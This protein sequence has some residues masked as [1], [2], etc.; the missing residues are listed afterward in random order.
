MD[1]RHDRFPITLVSAQNFCA[2]A[3]VPPEIFL[4]I[5]YHLAPDDLLSL[6]LVCK[7]YRIYLCCP[8]SSI[9]Q[10]IWRRSRLLYFP[11][12][13][14]PPPAGMDEKRYIQL[15][16]LGDFCQ[17]CQIDHKIRLAVYWP[18]RLR[19][20]DRCLKARIASKTEIRTKLCTKKEK[21]KILAGLPYIRIE[22]VSFYLR[23]QWER[24]EKKYLSLDLDSRTV[25]IE[26]QKKIAQVI[27]KD[28]N[29]RIIA[30][31]ERNNQIIEA[32]IEE[33]CQLRDVYGNPI[34]KDNYLRRSPAYCKAKYNITEP[35]KDDGNAI[36]NSMLQ[37]YFDV[38]YAIEYS[39]RQIEIERRIDALWQNTPSSKSIFS[40][41]DPALEY[42]RFCPHYK[43]PKFSYNDPSIRWNDNQLDFHVFMVKWEANFLMTNPVHLSYI[44]KA[45]TNGF[46]KQKV[47]YCAICKGSKKYSFDD[48]RGHLEGQ[49]HCI[50]RFI[51]D[52]HVL[53]DKETMSFLDLVSTQKSEIS[54]RK[55]RQFS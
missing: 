14:I 16:S 50:L 54:T 9:T 2:A 28:A 11:L 48:V 26:E 5:V 39:T 30:I 36:K 40:H 33:L 7:N 51:E 41:K 22:D 17:I 6:S 43:Y 20:C 25:W 31:I 46:K 52:E 45:L 37:T 35:I 27:M 10:E 12:L 29:L 8:N 49:F 18:F 55:F 15:T 53:V 34:Y 21:S 1:Q 42:L 47:F 44:G 3:N 19:C 23:N 13:S 32:I 38:S 24:A 4:K